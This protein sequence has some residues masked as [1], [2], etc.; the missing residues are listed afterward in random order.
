MHT[1]KDVRH[2]IV[3]NPANGVEA[4]APP[5]SDWVQVV[6]MFKD[7]DNVLLIGYVSTNY[8]D[9]SKEAPAMDQILGYIKDWSC[10]GIFFDETKFSSTNLIF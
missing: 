10:Q 3:L 5:N 8:G 2:V 9:A 7:K 4:T 1:Y 6:D